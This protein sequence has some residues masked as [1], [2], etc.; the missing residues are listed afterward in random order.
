MVL[1]SCGY[2]LLDRMVLVLV[3]HRPNVSGIL[4]PPPSIAGVTPAIAVGAYAH[5]VLTCTGVLL[6]GVS[7]HGTCYHWLV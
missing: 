6:R 7:A 2:L 3:V 4:T 5:G 1:A